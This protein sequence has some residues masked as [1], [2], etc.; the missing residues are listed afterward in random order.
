MKTVLNLEKL[1]Q[2]LQANWTQLL[3]RTTLMRILLED[4]RDTS[5][6]VVEQETVSPAHMKLTITKFV[7]CC[8]TKFE[9]W[10]EFT[11]PKS[12]GIVQGSHIYHLDF[13]GEL[14]LQSTYGVHFLTKKE[15][16]A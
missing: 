1:D 14:T 16:G 11:V 5:Y 10:V 3:D 9:L 4:V 8:K 13:D 12:E 6:Q 2:L 15:K 7:P